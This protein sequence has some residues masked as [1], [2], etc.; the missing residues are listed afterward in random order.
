MASTWHLN[1]I[2]LG[3]SDELVFQFL[4]HLRIQELLQGPFNGKSSL[5]VPL[6]H[7][8]TELIPVVEL[9]NFIKVGLISSVPVDMAKTTDLYLLYTT[10]DNSIRCFDLKLK[11]S[12]HNYTL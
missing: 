12:G 9:L 1:N 8:V 11:I 7:L 5:L 10:L 2:V 3:F 4:G 6:L